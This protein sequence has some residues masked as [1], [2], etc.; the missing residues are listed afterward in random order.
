MAKT[1]WKKTFNKDYLGAWDIDEGDELKAIISRVE[2]R[3]VTDTNGSKSPCNV[4]IFKDKKI[5]PMILN[6]GNSKII[7]RFVGTPYIEDWKDVAIQVYVDENVRAFGE[8]TEGL[9]I[10]EHQPRM[11]KDALRPGHPKWEGAVTKYR[12]TEDLSIVKKYFE[13]SPSDEQT[14]IDEAAIPQH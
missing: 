7:Q 1:H 11:T 14:L 13:L 3:D 12:E 8:I 4:A 5:K 9:R 2:V 6:V 10:R